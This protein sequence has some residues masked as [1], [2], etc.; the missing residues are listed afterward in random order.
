MKGLDGLDPLQECEKLV[1]RCGDLITAFEKMFAASKTPQRSQQLLKQTQEFGKE[2]EDLRE[3]GVAFGVL[4]KYSN[5]NKVP[6]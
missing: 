6:K 3:H 5:T 4:K 2:T 1:H